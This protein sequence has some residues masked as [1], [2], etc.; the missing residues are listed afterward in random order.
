MVSQKSMNIQVSSVS[1]SEISVLRSHG[2]MS[3][4]LTCEKERIKKIAAHATKLWIVCSEKGL[5]SAR[6]RPAILPSRSIPFFANFGENIM[7][8]CLRLQD[9]QVM[10]MCSFFVS[11][12]RYNTVWRDL[13]R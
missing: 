9:E 2:V 10:R 13:L 11:L 6:A 4:Q 8:C 5:Q 3:G 7:G 1:D 12:V